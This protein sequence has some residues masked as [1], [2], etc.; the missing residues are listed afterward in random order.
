[1]RTSGFFPG[2]MKLTTDIHL[3]IRLRIREALPQLPI[4][5]HGLMIKNRN[6][7]TFTQRVQR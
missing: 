3:L 4:S 1:M 7:F 5:L 2:G 6:N